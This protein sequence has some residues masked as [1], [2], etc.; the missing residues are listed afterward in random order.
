M[1]LQ[2]CRSSLR[3]NPNARTDLYFLVSGAQHYND[4][5]RIGWDQSNNFQAFMEELKNLKAR[6]LSDIGRSLKHTFE[7]LN[8][9]RL[10][11]KTQTNVYGNTDTYGQGQFPMHMYANGSLIIVITDAIVFTTPD[12]IQESLVI[13][14]TVPN[15]PW[16]VEPFRWDQ[17]RVVTNSTQLAIQQ[18]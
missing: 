10:T 13:P 14:P 2:S 1:C 5:V 18:R 16:T 7:L 3:R 11:P 6:D 8:Q 9:N 15:V 12:G 17:V 4:A